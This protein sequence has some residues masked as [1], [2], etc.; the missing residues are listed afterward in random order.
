MSHVTEM[1]FFVGLVELRLAEGAQLGYRLSI[2]LYDD[3][4]A[5]GS[6]SDQLGSVGA[7]ILN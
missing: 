2:S 6:L 7:E 1:R 3:H 4:L 5:L